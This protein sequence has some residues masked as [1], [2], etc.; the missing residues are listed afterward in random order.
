M[1]KPRQNAA[2]LA[3]ALANVAR[4][5]NEWI[6]T[7][8]DRGDYETCRH[9]NLEAK[10]GKDGIVWIRSN[11]AKPRILSMIEESGASVVHLGPDF[12]LIRWREVNK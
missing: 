2:A 1:T 9:H 11:D 4:W 10:A 8:L 12:S 3:E 7:N 6:P 5:P